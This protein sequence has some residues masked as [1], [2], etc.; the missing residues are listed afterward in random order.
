MAEMK[1]R[2]P[3]RSDDAEKP[4]ES[5]E[6]CTSPEDLPCIHCGYNL[7]GLATDGR[8]PECGALIARSIRGD[9]LWRAD[10]AWLARVS[11]GFTLTKVCF[12]TWLAGIGVGFLRGIVPGFSIVFRLFPSTLA[13]LL[14]LGIFRVM[15]PDPRLSLTE[16]P[17]VLRRIVRGAAIASLLL[18]LGRVNPISS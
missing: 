15:T 12:V 6:Q 18:G 13:T 9:L 1:K 8:C 16:Q 2:I 4:S 3:G 17:I 14:L 10:P 11:G 7:R 5:Q